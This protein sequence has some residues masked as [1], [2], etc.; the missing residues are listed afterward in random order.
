MG[1]KLDSVKRRLQTS[2]VTGGLTGLLNEGEAKGI[3]KKITQTGEKP[4]RKGATAA[5]RDAATQI[6]K[7]QQT[8]T[9]RLAEAESEIAAKRSLAGSKKGRRS[10]LKSS[11][12]GGLA[13]NLG[14]T[15][16]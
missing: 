8:E 10:L 7:Q 15:S 16:A 3:H 13:T 1:D 6:A 12:A 11:P 4:F 14:G 2:A 9:I 5:K